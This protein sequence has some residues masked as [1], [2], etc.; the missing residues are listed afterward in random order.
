MGGRITANGALTG[1]GSGGQGGD[2]KR[3]IF[4]GNAELLCNADSP[5]FVVNASSIELT[6]CSLVFTTPR[7]RLFGASPSNSGSLNLTILFGDVTSEGDEPLTRLNA[8]FLQIGKLSLPDKE[9]WSFCISG[10]RDE[11]CIR[12]E[13]RT[14]Q[15]LLFSTDGPGN[16]SVRAFAESLSGFLVPGDSCAPFVV[17]SNL[18]FF[19]SAKFVSSYEPTPTATS[20]PSWLDSV[21][22]MIMAIAAGSL[23]LAIVLHRVIIALL[24]RRH[25]KSPRIELVSESALPDCDVLEWSNLAIGK[26][27]TATDVRYDAKK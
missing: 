25:R 21:N 26:R 20:A 23:G 11:R 16:Y 19:P 1:I 13:A 5:S 10:M 4:S 3:L 7:K 24:C 9:S 15:S 22:P 18:S 17:E 27:E 14:V 2:V 6:N 8:T 12:S